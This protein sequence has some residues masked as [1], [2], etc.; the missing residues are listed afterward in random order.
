[1][2][3]GTGPESQ[4]GLRHQLPV[5]CPGMRRVSI[6]GVPRPATWHTNNCSRA[7]AAYMFVPLNWLMYSS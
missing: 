3:I 7:A 6:V 4:N 1:M 5:G 2:W